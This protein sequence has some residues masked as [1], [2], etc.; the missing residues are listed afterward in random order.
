M[1]SSRIKGFVRPSERLALETRAQDFCTALCCFV[2]ISN[3][4]NSQIL[5]S[6]TLKPEV[7]DASARHP[8]PAAH[9]G[10]CMTTACRHQRSTFPKPQVTLRPLA[11]PLRRLPLKRHV[12]TINAPELRAAAD[13]VQSGLVQASNLLTAADVWCRSKWVIRHLQHAIAHCG[14]APP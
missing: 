14:T 7:C 2:P 1:K 11:S 12:T 6:V 5:R 3:F 10:L 13:A 8:D 4:S 9:T